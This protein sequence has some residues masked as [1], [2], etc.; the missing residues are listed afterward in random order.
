MSPVDLTVIDGIGP[1]FA[2]RLA[3]AGITTFPDLAT[4]DA[5]VLAATAGTSPS[6]A[7]AW[8]TQAKKL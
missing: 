8:I 4:A 6:K 3:Q 5:T 7:A 1:V 2:G